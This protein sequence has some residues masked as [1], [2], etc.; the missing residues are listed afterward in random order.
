MNGTKTQKSNR[1]LLVVAGFVNGRQFTKVFAYLT[2]K[3]NVIF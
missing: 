3:Q 2:I 1:H